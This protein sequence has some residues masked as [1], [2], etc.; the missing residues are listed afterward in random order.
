M[1]MLQFE[2]SPDGKKVLLPI[3]SNRLIDYEFGTDK[4]GLP[5]FDDEGFDDEEVSSLVPTFKGND[6]ISF[7]VSGDSHYF[8]ETQ[9]EDPNRYEIIVL[10]R[11]ALKGRILS[12]SWPDEIMNELKQEN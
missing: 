9:R 10:D 4:V 8:D 5:I 7:L 6:E 12:E 2:L 11:A 1:S 3:K